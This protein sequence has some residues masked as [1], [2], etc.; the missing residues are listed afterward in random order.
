MKAQ[1]F[2]PLATY[3]DSSSELIISNA[4]AF[5]GFCG[6]NLH[7]CALRVAIPHIPKEWSSLLLDTPKMIEHAETLSR[8]RAA[9]LVEA[10][11]NLGANAKIGLFCRT[12]KTS[13]PL[14]HET[15]A[16]EARFFDLTFLE[17]IADV[18]SPQDPCRRNRPFGYCLGRKPS[19]RSGGQ[20]CKAAH[21]QGPA[22]V[23]VVS[24]GRKAAAGDDRGA[25]C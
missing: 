14:L 18:L 5:A 3:P 9:K 19:S 22:C 23:G 7:V 8:N 21:S 10:A 12:V 4:V 16:A 2:L 1:Y 11:T 17:C 20:R 13:L 6:A 15:A 24:D 25:S